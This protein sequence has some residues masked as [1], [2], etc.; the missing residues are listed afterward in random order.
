MD[1]TAA[2]CCLEEASGNKN[3][4]CWRRPCPSSAGRPFERGV[5]R[6]SSLPEAADPKELGPLVVQGR[7]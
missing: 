6:P 5:G 3:I 4:L 1:R 2:G 7:F